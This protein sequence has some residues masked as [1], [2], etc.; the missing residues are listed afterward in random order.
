[1]SPP[2][3][4]AALTAL[5]I[6]AGL[7]P[8]EARS[9]VAALAHALESA[10]VLGGARIVERRVSGVA[11]GSGGPSVTSPPRSVDLVF[12]GGDARRWIGT[13]A[14]VERSERRARSARKRWFVGV[15][16]RDEQPKSPA[17]ATP[18]PSRG[19]PGDLEIRYCRARG[20]GGQHVNRTESAVRVRHLPTGLVVRVEDERSRGRNLAVAMKRIDALLEA[21]AAS[22]VAEARE[23]RRSA[24]LAVERG[25]PVAIWRLADGRLLLEADA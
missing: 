12:E 22:R 2:H 24:C 25:R 11:R 8:I 14:L 7:G 15:T 4:R 18:V 13:H 6:S 9:F 10:L 1:M 17:R 23:E 21:R 3:A 16:L 5:T 20:P 19:S